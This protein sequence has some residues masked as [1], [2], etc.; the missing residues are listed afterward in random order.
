MIPAIPSS[1]YFL[2]KHIVVLASEV[3]REVEL[4]FPLVVDDVQ[5]YDATSGPFL[6]ERGWSRM[7]PVQPWQRLH[8]HLHLVHEESESPSKGHNSSMF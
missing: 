8:V 1:L 2:I 5:G 4:C 6:Q 3:Q 7:R